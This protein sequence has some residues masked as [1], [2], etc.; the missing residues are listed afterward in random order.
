MQEGYKFVQNS[1]P[2]HIYEIIL[3]EWKYPRLNTL[4]TKS[5]YEACVR[6]IREIYL[7]VIWLWCVSEWAL[8]VASYIWLIVWEGN[9]CARW[10]FKEQIQHVE[11]VYFPLK[12]TPTRRRERSNGKL[13]VETQLGSNDYG[14]SLVC[15]QFVWWENTFMWRVSVNP[16]CILCAGSRLYSCIYIYTIFSYV[17]DECTYW[18]GKRRRRRLPTMPPSVREIIIPKMR[19]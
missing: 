10:G 18:V 5:R 17:L 16:R 1:E 4:N 9:G 15:T 14:V 8:Y 19:S 11:A 12:N 13:Y 6:Y 3:V 2:V 7:F